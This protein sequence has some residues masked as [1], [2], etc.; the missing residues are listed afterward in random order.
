MTWNHE[1]TKRVNKNRLHFH[2][3]GKKVETL[4][5]LKCHDFCQLLHAQIVRV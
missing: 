4:Q 5:K 2:L 1:N 3:T